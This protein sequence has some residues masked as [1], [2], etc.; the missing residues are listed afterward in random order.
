MKTYI[1]DG[2]NAQASLWDVENFGY[3]AVYVAKFVRGGGDVAV[4]AKVPS[5][6]GDK[7]EAERTV[8]Q[9]AVGNEIILGPATVFTKENVDEFDF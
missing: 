6:A 8:T 9:G 7:G 2:S 1:K 3:V 4:G 5:G